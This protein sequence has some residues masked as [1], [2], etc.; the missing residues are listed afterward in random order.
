MGRAEALA[1]AK[2]WLAGLK[3]KHAEELAARYAG[4]L[5]RGTEGEAKPL[6][7]GKPA[8]LPEGD[9]PFAHPYYWAAFTLVG[10]PS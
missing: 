6:V 9:R 3:R 8:R 10:D 5:L 2:K 4:G 1:E 7:K